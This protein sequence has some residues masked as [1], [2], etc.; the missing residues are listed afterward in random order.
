MAILASISLNIAAI[1][2][3]TPLDIYVH[4]TILALGIGVLVFGIAVITTCR[5]V[6]GFFHLLQGKSWRTRAYSAYARYHTYYWVAFGL[7]LMLH[8]LVTIVHVGAPYAGEPY[9]LEHQIV[10]YTAFTNSALTLL[11]FASCRSCLRLIGLFTTR[12][13]FSSRFFKWY[14]RYHSLVWWLLAASFVV[15]IVAGII[16]AVNT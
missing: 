8:L 10:F 6:A 9:A 4:W 15:H 11:V 12:D 3:G 13:P 16:H 5:S 7:F 2:Q 14:Y 1:F